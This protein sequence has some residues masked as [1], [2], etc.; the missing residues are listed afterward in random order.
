MA[1]QY[2][3]ADDLSGAGEHWIDNGVWYVRMLCVLV[4]PR[5]EEPKSAIVVVAEKCQAERER[6]SQV[7]L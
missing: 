1:I 6:W 2:R 7:S 5:A 3:K 4:S